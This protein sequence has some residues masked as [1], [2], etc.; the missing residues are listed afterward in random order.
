MMYNTNK[1]L[2][3]Q[4]LTNDLPNAFGPYAVEVLTDGELDELD[5]NNS[6][7]NAPTFETW[8]TSNG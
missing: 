7:R 8:E 1:Q 5:V 6:P 3:S 4:A 2:I